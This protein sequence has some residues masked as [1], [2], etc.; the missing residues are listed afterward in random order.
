MIEVRP[1]P[2]EELALFCRME[3]DEDT[4]DH[5]TPQSLSQ[6]QHEFKRDDIV[7]LSIQESVGLRRNLLRKSMGSDIEQEYAV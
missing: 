2:P 7:N 4:R 3:Q 1:T 6:H 5:I